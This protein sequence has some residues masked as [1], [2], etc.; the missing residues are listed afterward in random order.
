MLDLR[1]RCR[2]E[3]GPRRPGVETGDRRGYLAKLRTKVMPPHRDTVR[4]VDDD[5]IK[6]LAAECTA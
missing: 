4:F 6:L 1:G 5:A 2:R 3:A